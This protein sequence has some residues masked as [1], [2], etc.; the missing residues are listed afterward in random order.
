M[1]PAPFWTSEEGAATAV[2]LYVFAK[3]IGKTPAE[4]MRDPDLPFNLSVMRGYYKAKQV[5]RDLANAQGA[6]PVGA[7]IAEA[8]ESED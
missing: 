1:P 3:D 8:I 5:A 2:E 4:A 6:D 7:A